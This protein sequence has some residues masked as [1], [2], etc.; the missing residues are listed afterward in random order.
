MGLLVNKAKPGGSGTSNDG[1]TAR[2]FF[3]NY[4]E[5]A[6]IT[7]VDEDLIRRFYVILQNISSGFEL[8]TEEFDKYTKDTA[9]LFIQACPWFY[10]PASVLVHGAD[11]IS[12]AICLL[13]NCPRKPRNLET[14]ISSPS[15]EVIREKCLDHK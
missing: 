2:R 5:S 13:D 14:R 3:K 11:I 12:R 8:N 15:D 7:G 4:R 6:R 1:N 10:M 9:K